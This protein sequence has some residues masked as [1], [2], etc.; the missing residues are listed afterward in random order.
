M[1]GQPQRWGSTLVYGFAHFGKSLLWYSSEILF[2]FFLT[3]LAGLRASQMGVVLAAGFVASAFIDLAVALTLRQWLVASGTAGR[4]QLAGSA[5]SS[6]MLGAVFAGAWL[7]ADIRYGYALIAGVAFRVAY[8][9]YDIP[10]NALMSLATTDAAS[11]RS[12]ASTRIWFSGGATLTIAA[13]IGP[14]IASSKRSEGASLLVLLSAAFAVVAV[15]S[16]FM[17]SRYLS[18]PKDTMIEERS[19]RRWHPT[20]EFWL[21]ISMSFATTIF[22]PAFAKLVPYVADQARGAGLWGSLTIAMMAVGIMGG[23]P[24]WLRMHRHMSSGLVLIAA[25]V[26]QIGSLIVFWSAGPTTSVLS[27]VA[28]IGFGLGNGG[29]GMVMWAALS[30]VVARSAPGSAGVAYGLFLAS[31]KIGLALGGGVIAVAL[32]GVSLDDFRDLTLLMLMAAIPAV[33]AICLIASGMLFR[34]VR[35][36]RS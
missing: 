35:P 27:A 36:A 15:I 10:Q 26:A 25:S 28:A 34:I 6:L 14:M 24:L 5:I 1:L 33:G 19:V 21:I 12:V 23:Q 18:A 2:A 4:L 32:A 9:L 16:A 22:T 8:A 13:V 31:N 7:P 3:E 11:R 30:D 17:L 29:V 20:A